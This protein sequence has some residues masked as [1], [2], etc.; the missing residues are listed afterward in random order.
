MATTPVP[1]IPTITALL[2]PPP[3]WSVAVIGGGPFAAL[4]LFALVVAFLQRLS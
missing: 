3:F 4:G 2:K 1:L